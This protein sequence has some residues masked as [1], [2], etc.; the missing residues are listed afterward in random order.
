MA[1]HFSKEGRR[2][3]AM[4]SP[5]DLSEISGKAQAILAGF[6]GLPKSSE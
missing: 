1:S 6:A 5:H 3:Y 4:N 2:D